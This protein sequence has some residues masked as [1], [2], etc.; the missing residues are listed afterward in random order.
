MEA[1]TSL[2]VVF[3]AYDIPESSTS[4]LD[5]THLPWLLALYDALT[6][7]DVEVREAAAHAARPLLGFA[8]VPVEAGARLLRWL[9][10]RFGHEPDFVKHVMGRMVGHNFGS[11]FFIPSHTAEG[12]PTG[13]AELGWASAERQLTEALRFDDS[14]FVIEEHN[15]YIDE[16][17]EAKRWADVLLSSYNSVSSSARQDA[18]KVLAEW[19]LA[20]LHT[21]TRIA[22]AEAAVAGDGPLGWTSKPQVFAICARIL[23][24][25][26]T[27]TKLNG[28]YDGVSKQRK[29]VYMDVKEELHR[30]WRLG[31]ADRVRVHG[32]LLSMCGVDG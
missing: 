23:I 16:V 27:I 6:D 19:T 12:R 24:S 17:R 2:S 25:A 14:L 11:T 31:R 30:F 21:L 18:S 7:D 28:Y 15:Q 20:G 10:A 26:C 1:I 4:H 22:E 9:A 3:R 29:G 13:V 5:P 32:L 8:L